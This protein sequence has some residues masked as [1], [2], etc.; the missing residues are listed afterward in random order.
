MTGV[1]L[2][3]LGLLIFLLLAQGFMRTSPHVLAQGVRAGLILVSIV[4]AVA[5]MATGRFFFVV[6]PLGALAAV[7]ATSAR[8]PMPGAAGSAGAPGRSSSSAMTRAEAM[9][10]LGLKEGATEEEIMAAYRRLMMQN[11]PDH[12]GSTYLAAKIN[13]AKD[14]LLGK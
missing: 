2:G 12:G 3:S 4:A 9:S 6:L 5:L 10:V 8:R 11:H 7:F 14:V 1:I 13:Q